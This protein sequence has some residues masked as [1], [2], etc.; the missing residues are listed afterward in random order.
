MSSSW[1]AAL[2]E[3]AIEAHR[4][5]ALGVLDL[6]LAM[7]VVDHDAPNLA[8]V[9]VFLDRPIRHKSPPSAPGRFA[10]PCPRS[11]LPRS[12]STLFSLK[13]SASS[14]CADLLPVSQCQC[15]RF[16]NRVPSLHLE[17]ESEQLVQRTHA[18]PCVTQDQ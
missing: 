2:F 11:G 12:A 18:A 10:A 13:P 4:F 15:T 5:P 14:A 8:R 3:S 17:H 6:Q 16:R 1:V 9:D 7:R